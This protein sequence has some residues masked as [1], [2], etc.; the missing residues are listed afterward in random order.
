M[1]ALKKRMRT[2]MSQKQKTKNAEEF[3]CKRITEVKSFCA[4]EFLN[5]LPVAVLAVS[6]HDYFTGNSYDRALKH[7]YVRNVSKRPVIL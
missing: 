2:R 4:T 1:L 5:M 6:A 3:E 7:I